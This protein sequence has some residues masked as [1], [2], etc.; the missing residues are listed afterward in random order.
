MP[1]ARVADSLAH[2]ASY[3]YETPLPMTEETVSGD[4]LRSSFDRAAAM[5]GAVLE[6]RF[7][8][9]KETQVRRVLFAAGLYR[10]SPRTFLG[11]QVLSLVGVALVG[12]WWAQTTGR[13]PVFAVAALAGGAYI[14]FRLPNILLRQRGKRR[15]GQ[16]ELELPELIDILVVTIEA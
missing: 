11:Y 1:R 3:G 8:S 13:A 16:I 5:L 14:G 10:I 15:M 12:L 9:V 7:D 2:I 6:R 4:S